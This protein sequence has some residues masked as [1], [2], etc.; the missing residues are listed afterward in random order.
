[1]PKKPTCDSKTLLKQITKLITTQKR[2]EK[3]R[4]RL[5][6]M[7]KELRIE[8]QNVN[9]KLGKKQKKYEKMRNRLEKLRN[10]RDQHAHD[11]E[12]KIFSLQNE[13][14][15]M[16]TTL[17]TDKD[18]SDSSDVVDRDRNRLDVA[19]DNFTKFI[20]SFDEQNVDKLLYQAQQAYLKEIAGSVTPRKNS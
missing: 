2:S 16:K 9:H 20:D 1:M 17:W 7:N 15:E 18:L 13:I 11:C 10:E 14:A 4:K 3:S 12:T 8:L 6:R 19:V 5:V